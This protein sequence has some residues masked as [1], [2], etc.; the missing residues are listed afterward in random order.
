MANAGEKLIYTKTHCRL[1]SN[2]SLHYYALTTHQG[3]ESKGNDHQVIKLSIVQQTL[4]V[5]TVG[6][7]MRT[8]RRMC[9]L[10]LGCKKVKKVE[11]VFWINHREM[12][13]KPNAIADYFRHSN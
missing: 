7:V 12:N 5:S 3:H 9:I 4:L 13:S 1:V 8:V 10:M 6:N 2:F 11:R